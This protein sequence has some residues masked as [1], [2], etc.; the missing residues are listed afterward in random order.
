M[1]LSQLKKYLFV[2]IL[3]IASIAYPEIVEV[4]VLSKVKQDF[5]ENYNRNYLPRDL[6]VVVAL[7]DLLF[8]S[9]FPQSRQIDKNIYSKL[10]PLLRKIN[11]NPKA[12][13]IDQLILTNDKYKN[14]LQESDFPNFVNE[15]SNSR[16]PIIAVNKGFTG[17]F[18]NIPKFEIWFAN[19]LKKNFDIDFSNSFPNNNY[20]IFNNLESFVNTYPVFY[21]G[22]LT[23]NNIP[24]A[25]MMIHFLIQMSFMPKAFIMVSSS[26]ELLKSIEAQLAS[27][28]S[29]ILFIG[30][31]YNNQNAE[32]NKDVA[33]YINLINDLAAQ[34]DKIKRNNT[35]LGNNNIKGKNPYDKNQ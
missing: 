4:N 19:H 24:E 8:K 12:I 28:S 27:Y 33:Y 17:N 13:Y 20:I 30:Y 11:N 29:S 3:L 32:E 14:E 2:S 26:I 1:N 21:K 7:D 16:I 9:L 31:Y 22:I 18:N 34:M 23:S 6:L 10:T 35:P 5:K 25:E 15:I